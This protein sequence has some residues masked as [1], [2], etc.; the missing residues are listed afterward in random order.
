MQVIVFGPVIEYDLSLPRIL[1]ISLRDHDSSSVGRHRSTEPQQLDRKL[2]AIARNRW[3]V[4]Y[5]SIYEDLNS[6]QPQDDAGGHAQSRAEYP[7]LVGAGIPLLFD[8]DHLTPQG[9]ILFAKAMRA[10]HQLP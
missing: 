7:V 3:N 6:C 5:I 9:S 4:R 2:A 8:T 10:C 1:A